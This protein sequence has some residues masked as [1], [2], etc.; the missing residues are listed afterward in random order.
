MDDGGD[1]EIGTRPLNALRTQ[2]SVLATRRRA[3]FTMYIHRARPNLRTSSTVLG[4]RSLFR[5]REALQTLA[6]RGF[7]T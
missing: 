4:F 2:Y 3:L 5:A 1:I 6:W 7:Q